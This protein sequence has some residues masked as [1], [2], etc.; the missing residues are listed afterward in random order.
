MGFEV[1]A[2]LQTSLQRLDM[3][4]IKVLKGQVLVVSGK[5]SSQVEAALAEEL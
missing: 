2:Q 3:F 1:S 4:V 5:P